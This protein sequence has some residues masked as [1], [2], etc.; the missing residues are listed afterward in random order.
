[1][2][3]MVCMICGKRLN[4]YDEYATLITHEDV[5]EEVPPVKEL[6]G[7]YVC[8]DCWDKLV[9]RSETLEKKA[10]K[11]KSKTEEELRIAL[12]NPKVKKVEDWGEVERGSGLVFLEVSGIEISIFADDLESFIKDL[13][14]KY[15]NR[16][17]PWKQE[18]CKG[19]EG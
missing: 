19:R 16:E 6:G 17:D 1:M 4:V 13:L 7:K 8:K 18:T 14:I 9:K 11:V 2:G 5:A 12:I 3:M 10:G 15:E